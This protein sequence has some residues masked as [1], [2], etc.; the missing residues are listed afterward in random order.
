MNAYL[1]SAVAVV[2]F[3]AVGALMLAQA[4]GSRLSSLRIMVP[5]TP[6][7]S[8]DYLARGVAKALEAEKL[9]DKVEVYYGVVGDSGTRGLREFVKLRGQ[10]TE[11]FSM[12][13]GILAGST[14]FK[15]PVTMLDT[16]PIVRLTTDFEVISVPANSPYKTVQDLMNAMRTT[17]ENVRW[18]G[19]ASG[20]VAHLVSGMVA[21]E[22][23]V[24]GSRLKFVS[25]SGNEKAVR[26]MLNNES[27]VC[28][29][30]YSALEEFIKAGQVRVLATTAAEEDRV[31][32]APTLSSQGVNVVFRSWRGL[33]APP[34]I[35]ARDRVA[36]Q[37]M[38]SRMVQSQTWREVLRDNNW[39]TYFQS[40][41]SFRSFIQSEQSGLDTLLR[42]LQ[43][44]R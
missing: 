30:Q 22:A 37:F 12:G 42:S 13:V 16:T 2:V 34:G 33:V 14:Y 15:S 39:K 10:A 23:G 31:V 8:W 27:D 21:Q 6:G 29:T 40:G 7:A 28:V 44:V 25:S 43:L 17:P 4:Q 11:L 9:V 20:G 24:G 26:A 41:E 36:L 1:R 32:R 3:G 5:S 35:S 38:F 19:T 18:S